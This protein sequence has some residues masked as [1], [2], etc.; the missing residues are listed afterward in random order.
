[1]SDRRKLEPELASHSGP[2][3]CLYDLLLHYGQKAP[4]RAALLAAESAPIS[5]G[6]LLREANN[7][8]RVLRG[9]GVTRTDRVAVVLPSGPDA[10]AATVAVTAGA[11]CVPLNPCFTA[12]EWH[13]YFGY[14]GVAALVTRANVDSPCRAVARTLGIPI[15]DLSPPSAD[16]AGSFSLFA[17][18]SRTPV[19]A[20][21]TRSADDAFILLTSGTTSRPKMV[22]LTHASVCQSAFNAGASLALD[23]RDR[24]L[25][26]L[27]L[28]HAHGLIS[29]LLNALAA[30]SS[31]V[32]TPGFDADS[33]FRWLEEFRPTWFTAVPAIHR[34]LLSAAAR[35]KQNSVACSLRLIRSASSSLPP[36]VL[37]GL[38][39]LF[40]VP[41]I[42][43]Y[44]M[45]EGASQIAANPVKR[46]KTSSVGKPTG[47]EIAIMD[48]DG[49]RLSIA[50]HGEI[51]LRGATLTRGYCDDVAA[52]EMA[53]RDGWF[54]TGDLGYLDQDGYLFI[55][56]RIKDVINRGG[57]KIAPGEVEEVLLR[58]P[59]VVEAAVFSVPHKRLGEDVGAAVVL[60]PGAKIGAEKLRGFAANHLARYKVPGPIRIV[61]A[62]PKGPGGKLQRDRLA[63]AL[64][65]GQPTRQ[66]KRG[67]KVIPPRLK[68]EWELAQTWAELL[69]QDD[70][71]VDQD[72]FALGADSLT[73]TQMLSRLRARY[74]A[75]LAF[76]DICEAPTVR[77]LAAR[78]ATSATSVAQR[79]VWA[80][81]GV[82]L[83]YPLSLQ[84]HRFYVLSHLDPTGYDNQVIEIARLSGALDV[85]R[86]EASLAAIY[87]R[88]EVLRSTFVEAQ[89]E[90]MQ[91]PGAVRPR[92][93]YLNLGPRPRRELAAII[94]RQAQHLLREPIDLA[95]GPLLRTKL[96]RFDAQA[97]VLLIKLH[98]MITDGWSQRLFWRELQDIYA[99]KLSASPGAPP[100]LPSQYR[101]YV[102]WQRRWLGT[103]AAEK[104]RS[105]WRGQLA[106]VTELSLRWDRPRPAARSGRGA[107]LPFELSPTLSRRLK[108]QSRVHGVTLFMTLLA[109]FQCLL[110]RYTGQDEIAVGSLIANRT[111]IETE[112]LMGM[113]ANTIVLRT[114]LSGDPRFSELLWRVREVTSEAYRNQDLPLEEIL[115]TMKVPRSTDRNHLF[116]VMFIL[117]NSPRAPALPGLFVELL[118]VDPGIARS[119]LILELNDTNDCLKGWLEYS[120]DLFEAATIGRMA[121]HL[122][123]LLKA[124]VANPR[125]QI[126]MLPL[127]PANERN[128][129]L[130][131]WNDT[132]TN[133][134]RPG[135][136][137][138]QFA[139]QA[140]RTPD[141]TAVSASGMEIS[142]GEL[143]AMAR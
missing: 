28:F 55:V 49:R 43:T 97:H 60:R 92:L 56:G 70:I 20:Q 41:V 106:N 129:I 12:S 4:R 16:R 142:Y 130:V 116:Q 44:G 6:V 2:F 108:A 27:P 109:A 38:E 110:H 137:Y 24:L 66:P 51:C 124:I 63:G 37:G 5:Y 89:G 48:G 117:R 8:I 98:H 39:A 9:L 19:Y 125:D 104:Q 82:A 85:A 96:L 30:G 23:H 122:D 133:F 45:T 91:K 72:V 100:R 87:D 68:L 126:S 139:A 53:F 71:P 64:A 52:N 76:K 21:A 118:D 17:P 113:F 11:I 99:A 15:I 112:P 134:G 65:I 127:L 18:S 3:P 46:R 84:Q 86:L 132:K 62:I 31:V 141:A 114:D 40:G 102:E 10:A 105:Y 29:G 25:N 47:A 101:H 26:V 1:M 78:I 14:L 35:R 67:A 135:T 36:D 79:K 57:Q 119:D 50:E 115:R 81:K 103:P 90:T 32:C 74:G 111:Q 59:Q 61:S 123:T 75:D 80:T 131:H 34:A 136:F 121:V 83:R 94:K 88:H 138:E 54:R 140:E 69:E 107:R 7:A 13:R 73:A 58:H 93:E 95:K 120:T 22:P 42:E 143:H 77:A 128:Q 33:F